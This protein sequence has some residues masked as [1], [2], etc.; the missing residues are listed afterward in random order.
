MY[1]QNAPQQINLPEIGLSFT[2]PEG[3]TGEQQGEAI[4]LGHHT[5][6]GLIILF[7]N[8]AKSAEE[9]RALAV[10]GIVDVELDLKAKGEFI[11]Q[12]AERVQG[13]Y[14]GVLQGNKVK[15][16]AIGLINGLGSGMNIV[17]VTSEDK[18]TEQHIDEA[19]KIATS[20]TFSE[21]KDAKE[22]IQWKQWLVGRKL[23]YS[24]SNSNIDYMGGSTHMSDTTVIKLY[25]DGSF[26]FYSSSLNT[27]TSGSNQPLDNNNPSGGGYIG[28]Q[29][30]N[31]GTYTIYTDTKGSFLE[32]HFKDDSYK[33]YELGTNREKQTTLNGTRYYVGAIE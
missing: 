3:W 19:S 12:S 31:N 20:V 1:A 17:I 13:E 21:E 2:I 30:Q 29:D 11:L 4:L 24:Y 15:A 8:T 27:F 5:I 32:L 23:K 22:T 16:F 18:F 28:G 14:E 9:L 25:E 6:P 10:K 33:L 26:Y 7:Q